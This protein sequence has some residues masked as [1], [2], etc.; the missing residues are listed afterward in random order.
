MCRGAHSRGAVSEEVIRDRPKFEH[1]GDTKRDDGA[2]ES[3]G[4]D[5]IQQRNSE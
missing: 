4:A 2:V 5:H 3:T 1:D